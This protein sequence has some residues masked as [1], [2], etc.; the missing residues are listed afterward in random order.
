MPCIMNIRHLIHCRFN[1][2]ALIVLAIF[3]LSS[4]SVSAIDT[5]LEFANAFGLNGQ[6]WSRMWDTHI[7]QGKV[8]Y[9]ISDQSIFRQ[10]KND[11][12]E[13]LRLDE[14]LIDQYG[15]PDQIAVDVSGRIYVTHKFRLEAG[16]WQSTLI[17]YDQR[18]KMVKAIPLGVTSFEDL[19]IINGT[20]VTGLVRT[21]IADEQYLFRL[22]DIRN[23]VMNWIPIPDEFE[24]KPRRY[25]VHKN[26]RWL[27][28]SGLGLQENTSKIVELTDNGFDHLN[29]YTIGPD[30]DWGAISDFCFIGRSLVC[31]NGSRVV[32]ISESGVLI[33]RFDPNDDPIYNNVGYSHVVGYADGT[34][35]INHFWG[36]L[37]RLNLAGDVIREYGGYGKVFTP[38]AVDLAGTAINDGEVWIP[39]A[40][41]IQVLGPNERLFRIADSKGSPAYVHSIANFDDVLVYASYSSTDRNESGIAIIDPKSYKVKDRIMLVD[42]AWYYAKVFVLEKRGKPVVFVQAPTGLVTNNGRIVLTSG[43]GEL[44]QAG[45]SLLV[46]TIDGF[47]RMNADGRLSKKIEYGW[48]SNVTASSYAF[49]SDGSYIDG[50][51]M[52]DYL[53]NLVRY[54][55]NGSINGIV[56]VGKDRLLLHSNE[57][58]STIWKY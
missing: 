4:S 46:R 51:A 50:F 1:F 29:E 42:Q 37:L 35:M 43:Y 10:S 18:A 48:L 9:I 3:L 33:K 22:C 39:L 54:F 11:S 30:N 20:T 52:F 28:Y 44:K 40:S 14:S 21:K 13:E 15:T 36:S 16:L 41:G 55:E 45:N 53:G 19:E 5:K 23:G 58:V 38:G 32:V 56:A 31:A 24:R 2:V 34:F 27:A 7:A 25:R 57:Y 8:A 6:R 26:K 47:N 49:L 17:Q 12:F